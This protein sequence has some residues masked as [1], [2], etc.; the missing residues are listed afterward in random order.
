VII[1]LDADD[2]CPATL[3]GI[4]K[5]QASAIMQPEN[6]SVIIPKSE[7]EVWFVSAA[8]SLRGVRG[9][10]E[11]LAIP[12]DPEAIRGAKEW[13]SRN[14]SPGRKHSPSVDQVALAAKMDLEAAR[15]CRSFARLCREIRRLIVLPEADE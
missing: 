11:G 7:F 2:D 6:V 10:S 14:M 8:Q 3:G 1:F 9:L 12:S 4:L 15:S 5:S 13:L